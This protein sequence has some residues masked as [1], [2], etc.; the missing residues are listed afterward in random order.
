M[1]TDGLDIS[2]KQDCN[3]ISIQPYGF[4]LHSYIQ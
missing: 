3:L 1:F 4:I 2:V